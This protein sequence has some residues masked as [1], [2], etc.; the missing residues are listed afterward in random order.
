M[1][2]PATAT[3]VRELTQDGVGHIPANTNIAAGKAPAALA[4]AEA[5]A[6][7][8]VRCCLIAGDISAYAIAYFLVLRFAPEGN[9]SAALEHMLQLAALA[10]IVLSASRSLYPGY[11]IH[12]YERLRRRVMVSASVAMLALPGALLLPQGWRLVLPI[13]GFLAV[14]LAVQTFTQALARQLCRRLGI[15]GEKA[16]ILA[17]PDHLPPLT[18]YFSR[19]W[20]LGILPEPLSFP[21]Q[22]ETALRKGRTRE[23]RIVLIAGDIVPS[24]A[25]LAALR[26]RFAEIILLADTPT[27]KLSGLRPADMD[28]RIGLSL[29]G[30]GRRGSNLARR[31]LDLA[32][33]LPVALISAPLILAA[34]L[35]IYAID[36]GPVFFWHAREGR[37]GRPL[38]VLKL[39]TMYRDAEQ[40]LEALLRENPGMEAEW[41][42][43]FKLRRDPRILPVAGP[44]LRRTSLDELP[45]L[46]NI[47]AGDMTMVG[48]RPFPDYHLL[49]MDGAFRD[50]RHSV[51]PGLTGLWQISERSDADIG[52]QRQLDE[53]YIDN[54]SLWLDW[55]I[56]AGTLPAVLRRGGAY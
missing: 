55:H 50:K 36:P 27:L 54:R 34:A 20:R 22:D 14:A 19:H 10:A 30:G 6:R 15:W 37:D 52:L 25:E 48:P 56:L 8:A 11:R 43:H 35:A 41:S 16:A 7:P 31:T 4:P 29:A 45:Q 47:I 51:T 42:S 28:G 38:R 33:A 39:R 1:S 5:L 46:L 44:L 26:D 49:A 13:I 32:I 9:E 40:R 17:D 23:P 53:F 24:L 18:D 2:S 3:I 21:G 12:D